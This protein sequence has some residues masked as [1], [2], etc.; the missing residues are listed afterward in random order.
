MNLPGM[1]V[2]DDKE[3]SVDFSRPTSEE[4]FG[5]CF[6]GHWLQQLVSVKVIRDEILADPTSH[7]L[8]LDH[9]TSLLGIQHPNVQLFIGTA[10]AST[11]RLYLGMPPLCS[12]ALSFGFLNLSPPSAFL[13][14]HRCLL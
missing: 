3:L 9:V 14:L 10:L 5:V 12:F 2:I 6:R 1:Q 11:G 4:S 7:D 8:I 13:S